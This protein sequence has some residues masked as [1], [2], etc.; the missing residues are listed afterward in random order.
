MAAA[1]TKVYR[2]PPSVAGAGVDPTAAQ[3]AQHDR[4]VVDI[5]TDAGG[6]NELPVAIAHNMGFA[7]ADGSAGAPEV[8][9]TA[10][11]AGA[12]SSGLSMAFTDLNTLTFTKIITG[13]AYVWR[14]V[15]RRPF[16][17]GQ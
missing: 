5:T 3:M 17:V 6:V 10:T 7:P 1:M 11:T 9:V 16:S 13:V 4:L 14:V 8:F 15:I 2:Y 12:T